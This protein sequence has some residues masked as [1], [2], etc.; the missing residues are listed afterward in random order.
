M[1]APLRDVRDTMT[2]HPQRS[3][4]EHVD[5]SPTEGLLSAG[6]LWGAL[7]RADVAQGIVKGGSFCFEVLSSF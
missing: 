3:L 5:I 6:D 1:A 4:C 2:E 7:L